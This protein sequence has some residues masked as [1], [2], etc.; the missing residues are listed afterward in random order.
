MPRPRFVIG[1]DDWFDTLDWLDHQLSQ[2]T[3]LLDDDH[4]IHQIGLATFKERVRQCRYATQPTHPDCYVLQSLLTDSLRRSDWDRLRK[5]L[6]AR[7]RRRRER[8][9]DQSPVNITLSQHAHTWLKNL[10]EAGGY[11]TLSEALEATLPELVAQQEAVNQQ[12]RRQ[13]I[14]DTLS[15]WPTE[16]LLGVIERYLDRASR[17]RSLATACR[18]AYQWY[19]RDPDAHK[20]TLLKERFID[21]LVWNETHLKRHTENFLV[22]SQ[23]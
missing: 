6:S 8:R 11:D 2:P 7:R 9:L 15:T 19:Q 23:A 3:W 13:R 16:Q 20:E 12:Q 21:D 17:E 10:T 18:I 22:A 14:E 1:P 5:T 4:P